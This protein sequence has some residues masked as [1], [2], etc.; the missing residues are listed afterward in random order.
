MYVDGICTGQSCAL[1]KCSMGRH[2]NTKDLQISRTGVDSMMR[3]R[4]MWK[5]Q[6]R[7]RCKWNTICPNISRI[8]PG[9]SI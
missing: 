4:M 8:N 1:T 7:I 5:N 3:T 9:S 6:P 2:M